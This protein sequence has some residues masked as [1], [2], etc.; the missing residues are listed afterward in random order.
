MKKERRKNMTENN[1]EKKEKKE[2]EQDRGE[3]A[4]PCEALIM[5]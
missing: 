1:A 5:L 3:A 4:L 2:W